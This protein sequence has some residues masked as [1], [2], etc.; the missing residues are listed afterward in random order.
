VQDNPL[1]SGQEASTRYLDFSQQPLIDPVNSPETAA[2]L[3]SWM[4]LYNKWL[5]KLKVALAEE[6]PYDANSGKSERVW[7]NAV[8]ARAFDIMRGFLPVATSTLLSWTTNL[9]QARDRLMLL[10][11]HPLAEVRTL[12][13]DLYNTL[14]EKYPNSFN[15]EEMKADS[16]YA[17]RDDYA[18][19]YA[20]RDYYQSYDQ[21]CTVFDLTDAEKQTIQNG[22]V[23]CRT[24]LM[25]I[26]GMNRNESDVLSARPK[27]A[28]L[29]RRLGTYGQYGFLFALDFGSYRDIQRHRGGLGPMPLIDESLG[30]QPWYLSQLEEL[31]PNDFSTIM[32]EVN[33]LLETIREFD[34]KGVFGDKFIRQYYYPMGMRVPVSLS[35]HLPQTIYVAELRSSTTVHPTIR[36]LMQ[37]MGDK[38]AQLHPGIALYVNYDKAVWDIKRGEQ[39][40]SAKD[41]NAA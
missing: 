15:G 39:T 27:G 41:K 14:Y 12:A 6:F 32:T 7:Q 36:P 38:L 30:F 35:Y 31:L 40:I 17:P 5:A 28:A 34:A 26:E 18:Q 25:D 1:Y 37:Q 24:N 10:K 13:Q 22:D 16:R 2:L 11:N 21:M 23:V 33:Q 19:A 29:P 9:R 20:S 3:Q 8:N 4:D